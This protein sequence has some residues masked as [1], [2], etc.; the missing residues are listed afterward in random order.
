MTS[1][2]V[3]WI[4]IVLLIVGGLI[5][6]VSALDGLRRELSRSDIAIS[7]SHDDVPTSLPA[8]LTLCLFRVVQEALQNA[9]KYSGATRVLVHLKGVPGG[10][11]LTVTDDGV[12][13]DVSAA[14]NKGL[15]L[16][17]MG[18]RLEAIGG[19]FEIHSSPGAGT[20]LEATL[21]LGAS[22]DTE[23]VAV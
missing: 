21:P 8:D 19:T 18:E 7:F 11:A 16:V 1:N 5:G 12:G 2:I 14:W 15:G 23:T 10:L 3:L 6:L 20:Q 22:Q 4:Y 13:F 9:L 17:S